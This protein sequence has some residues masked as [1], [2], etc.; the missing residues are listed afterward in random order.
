MRFQSTP[1]GQNEA[2]LGREALGFHPVNLLPILGLAFVVCFFSGFDGFSQEF[3]AVGWRILLS[4]IMRIVFVAVFFA[5]L[6]SAG[7]L[8]ARLLRI[9]LSPESLTAAERLV[10]KFFFGAGTT[11]MV[12]LPLGLLKLYYTA[13]VFLLASAVLAFGFYDALCDIR[14]CLENLKAYLF[15]KRGGET[16]IPIRW[17]LMGLAVSYA[18]L[19]LVTRCLYP[20]ETSNDSYEIYWPYQMQTVSSHALLP[21]EVWYM[22]CSFNGAGL[23]FLSILLTDLLAVQSVT[24]C[25]L[26]SAILGVFCLGRRAGMGTSWAAVAALVSFQCFAFTNPYWGAFQSHHIQAGAWLVAV[27][28]TAMTFRVAPAEVG[29]RGALSLSWM[30]AAM[31]AFFPLFLIFV[32][33]MLFGIC[34]IEAGSRKWEKASGIA[35]SL[36]VGGGVAVMVMLV[37]FFVGGMFLPNPL[38]TMWKYSSPET[39]SKWCSPYNVHYLLE[40]SSERTTGIALGG[41]FSKG[42][43]FW[44]SLLRIKSYGWLSNPW[45]I[46]PAGAIACAA[47][48]RV[49]AGEWWRCQRILPITIPIITCLLITNTSHPDSVFRNYGFVCFLIPVLLG[50]V[51][52]LA[53]NEVERWGIPRICVGLAAAC[54]ALSPGLDVSSRFN[55]YQKRHQTD[56]I[57]DFVGF[58]VGKISIQE[59]LKRG[60]GLWPVTEHVKS[61]IGMDKKI[62]SFS[63][64]PQI[65]SFLFPGSGVLT[66]PSR[67]GF[68]NKFDVVMFGPPQTAKAEL[69]RQGI[70]YF[71]IDFSLPFFGA[72]PY[73]PLFDPSFLSERFDLVT[74]TGSAVLLTWKGMGQRLPAQVS[75]AWYQRVAVNRLLVDPHPDG[76][77]GRL[78]DNVKKIYDYNQGREGRVLRPPDLPK[79]LGW[80]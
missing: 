57:A 11:T 76:V 36:G 3:T 19:F 14:F 5:T 62:Y 53:A 13:A 35:L 26:I 65:A 18:L 41:L 1:Q 79:V 72:L 17:L 21:N 63:H 61:V 15:L 46:L 23:N 80:Q 45:F 48:A 8:T 27:V 20:G 16:A 74:G 44:I 77:M 69:E 50:S 32:I 30:V 9:P 55:D 67:Y 12:M 52:C 40:G 43:D 31:A 58:L 78:Y 54:L 70:N 25:F 51:F 60:D 4:N 71:L 28:W 73:C 75:T 68:L 49:K 2:A 29:L 7:G 10:L 42:G 22:F 37:N 39:F 6:L 34:A 56:R 66:E 64:P 47:L 59:A 33:P 24:Y 38:S